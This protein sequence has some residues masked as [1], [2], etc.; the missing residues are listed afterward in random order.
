MNE[1]SA[2]LNVNEAN[3]SKEETTMN[4]TTM[5]ETM[6]L[7]AE[8]VQE[9][10]YDI[11]AAEEEASYMAKDFALYLEKVGVDSEAKLK[12]W[13][14]DQLLWQ[15]EWP[16]PRTIWQQITRGETENEGKKAHWKV[17]WGKDNDGK[18]YRIFRIDYGKER[19][20]FQEFALSLIAGLGKVAGVLASRKKRAGNSTVPGSKSSTVSSTSTSSQSSTSSKSS[21]A[22]STTE[23]KKLKQ[24]NSSL[25]KEVENLRAV[26]VS[27]Y[28]RAKEEFSA[29]L[30][31][32][33][34]REKS[35]NDVAKK[36][37]E[38]ATGMDEA[39]LKALTTLNEA[40]SSQDKKT[41]MA[42]IKAAKAALAEAPKLETG[43]LETTE[44]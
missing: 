22:N 12:E 14:C 44:K 32:S 18:P 33:A 2:N 25:Y 23:M 15:Q 20:L 28:D 31:E 3:Q 29:L 11:G 9:R 1:N 34:K 37:K 30:E 5:N 16:G 38:Q 41:L 36:V 42:I 8:E 13:A 27:A 4:E 43:E 39:I 26:Q 17:L 21:T 6:S 7:S 10:L 40:K 35:A 19:E 24:E